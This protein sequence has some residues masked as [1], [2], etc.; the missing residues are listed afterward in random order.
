M[1]HLI[2]KNLPRYE[3]L[4]EAAQQFP[5]MD[6]SAMEA[7]LFLLKAG[8]DCVEFG[9]E[10]LASHGVSSGRFTV[11]MLIYK[12]QVFC[13]TGNS[14]ITP[15]ELADMAGCTRA[16]MT[17]LIDTLE[18]DRLV[19]RIPDEKDRRMMT[20]NITPKGS[21]LITKI[22]PGHLKRIA[23][24]MSCLNESERKTMVRLL[25]KVIGKMG[26][27]TSPVSV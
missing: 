27:G 26:A 22:M 16:T 21:A 7:Y 10:Y 13:P 4:R 15:A 12:R 8:T 2:P 25:D 1:A 9:H 20:V 23:D 3:C 17:G 18:R 6:P 5:D 24:L 14:A 19:K 11:L